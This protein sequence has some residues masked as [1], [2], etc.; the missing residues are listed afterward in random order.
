[1]GRKKIKEDTR[2]RKVLGTYLNEKEYKAWE[3]YKEQ[4]FEDND[5]IALRRIIILKIREFL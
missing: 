3:M 1:M 4:E 2:R 5:S